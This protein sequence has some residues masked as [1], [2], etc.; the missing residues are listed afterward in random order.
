[1]VLKL[2]YITLSIVFSLFFYY[3]IK[4]I[5]KKYKLNSDFNRKLNKTELMVKKDLSHLRDELFKTDS[6]ERR[7]EI[8][9]QIEIIT[10]EYIK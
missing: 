10:K 4:R 6:I 7:N 2:I 8:V 1:M 3:S 5:V 9:A